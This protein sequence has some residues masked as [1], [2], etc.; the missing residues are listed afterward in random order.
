MG[1][2]DIKDR[3]PNAETIKILE[4]ALEHARKGEIRS[5]VIVTGWD[6]NATAHAWSVDQRTWKRMLLGEVSIAQANLA[7]K[8]S[9]DDGDT[10][11]ARLLE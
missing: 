2:V 3:T 4:R 6:D 10:A 8:I 9:V 7:V 11:I 5:V 1:L